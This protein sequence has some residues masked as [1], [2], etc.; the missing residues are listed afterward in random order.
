[1][2]MKKKKETSRL[3]TASVAGTRDSV[4][5]E[6]PDARVLLESVHC[7]PS[8]TLSWISSWTSSR[9]LSSTLAASA[10]ASVVCN[11]ESAS[12][13]A[14]DSSSSNSSTVPFSAQF[15]TDSLSEDS[16][17]DDRLGL[18]QRKNRLWPL[19]ELEERHFPLS[20]PFFSL[21][22]VLSTS[23]LEYNK[24]FFQSSNE[25]CVA[26]DQLAIISTRPSVNSNVI[27]MKFQDR[28][29]NDFKHKGRRILIRA[30]TR[31]IS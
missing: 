22:K 1:M 23:Q 31:T 6:S 30:H 7:G 3:P 15:E 18:E 29:E 26:V 5:L 8:W 19:D 24:F 2:K 12:L 21:A 9:T 4:C 28:A 10:G 17:C 13:L 16:S 14:L 11:S 27:I 25:K 20:S